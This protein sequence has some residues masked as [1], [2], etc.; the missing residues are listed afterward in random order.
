[1]VGLSEIYTYRNDL[2]EFPAPIRYANGILL[3]TLLPFAFAWFIEIRR[4]ALAAIALALMAAFYPIV[5]TKLSIFAPFWLLF[6]LTLT[7][8]AEAR[9]VVILSM[10][11]PLVIGLAALTVEAARGQQVYHV[12]GVI[13]FRMIAIPS[14]ALEIYNAFFFDHQPTHFCQV[15]IVRTLFGCPYGPQLGV[16]IAKI[17][18]LGNFNASMLATE[19]IASVGALWAPLVAL[20]CGIAI[21]LASSMASHLPPRFVLLS[22]G[23]MV[24]QLI[25]LPLTTALLSHGAALLF[26]LWYLTSKAALEPAPAASA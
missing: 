23:V 16:E 14:I 18:D 12:F 7:R 5:L 21:A 8:F 9:C 24:Q 20:P 25:N 10:L 4:H 26:L 17:Y 2:V 1:M 11:L 22:S 6:L 13:N 19:G 3:S 15:N